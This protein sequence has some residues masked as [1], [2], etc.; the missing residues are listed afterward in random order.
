MSGEEAP[1]ARDVFVNRNLRMGSVELIGFDMDYTLA[2][3]HM[4]RLEQLSFDMT[5]AKLVGQ[6]GYTPVIGHLLYDHHFVMRG[7]AVDRVTRQHPEDGS[8]RARGARRG[9]GCG[10]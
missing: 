4:R 9:T 2:I 7:L 6:Y 3:Y 1:R 5:L 8:V 10:R